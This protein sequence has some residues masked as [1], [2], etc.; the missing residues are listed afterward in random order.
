MK[1]A[2]ALLERKLEDKNDQEY[3]DFLYTHF[4]SVRFS[5]PSGAI[6][7]LN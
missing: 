6:G 2:K 5:C 7:F 3:L 1:V 4:R